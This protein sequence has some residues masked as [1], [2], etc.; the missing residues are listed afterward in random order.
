MP[1]SLKTSLLNLCSSCA[2]KSVL[3]EQL[4]EKRD[5]YGTT[6]LFD[7]PHGIY[8]AV[9]ALI[10]VDTHRTLGWKVAE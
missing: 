8:I 5:H 10:Q 1:T 4:K 2:L 7:Y 3:S 6:F 9:I